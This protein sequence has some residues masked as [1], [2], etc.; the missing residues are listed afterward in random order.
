MIKKK[1]SYINLKFNFTQRKYEKYN[2][3]NRNPHTWVNTVMEFSVF[4]SMY[5][6]KKPIEL[7]SI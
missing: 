6:T 1:N 4:N 7:P 3:I 2:K 5:T